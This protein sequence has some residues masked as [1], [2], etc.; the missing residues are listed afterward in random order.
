MICLKQ[1]QPPVSCKY[2]NMKFT[3]FFTQIS[4]DTAWHRQ[5]DAEKLRS[6]FIESETDFSLKVDDFFLV[7]F[8]DVLS[9]KG[10]FQREVSGFP[11]VSTNRKRAS[12]FLNKHSIVIVF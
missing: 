10:H 12:F 3:H 8:P 11:S 7:Q 6:H 4:K 1:S 5:V 2:L 9:H